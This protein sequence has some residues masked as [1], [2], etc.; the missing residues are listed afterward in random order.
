[1]KKLQFYIVIF[2]LAGLLSCSQK[3]TS[4]YY[5]DN[6]KV[7]DGEI[8]SAYLRGFFVQDKNIHTYTVRSNVLNDELQG[9]RD[10]IIKTKPIGYDDGYYGYAFVTT[11]N[12]TLFADYNLTYWRYK[13]KGIFYKNDELKTII[14]K[15]TH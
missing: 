15:A 1:M 8:T 14:N 7:D 2:S 12:D 9:I 11:A 4:V 6:T 10:S 3:I 13:E 5:Y